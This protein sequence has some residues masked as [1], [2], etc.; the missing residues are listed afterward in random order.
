MDRS[1]FLI[2][3]TLVIAFII[4][5]VSSVGADTAGSHPGCDRNRF[6]CWVSGR[7]IPCVWTCDG[8]LDCPDGEDEVGCNDDNLVADQGDDSDDDDFDDD[9]DSQC[10]DGDFE[11]ANRECVPEDWRCDNDPDCDD[12][13]DEWNCQDYVRPNDDDEDEDEDDF[14]GDR[15]HH[16]RHNQGHGHHGNRHHGHA[17][18]RHMRRRH[19]S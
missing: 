11:C 6:V 18:F 15:R 16:Q 10:F 19:H 8:Q 1:S 9:S 5:T 13:S 2:L 12:G 4:G 7:N 3:I 17:H 14:F